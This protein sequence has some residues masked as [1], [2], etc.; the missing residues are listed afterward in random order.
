MYNE[1]LS[2]GATAEPRPLGGSSSL[3]SGLSA[4]EVAVFALL[5]I[6]L[7]AALLFRTARLRARVRRLE[8][9]GAQLSRTVA[10]VQGW[11]QQQLGAVRGEL[12]VF[13]MNDSAAD[14][15]VQAAQ[16]RSPSPALPSEV[17]DDPDA[18]RET[19]AMPAPRGHSGQVLEMVP[20]YSDR[21]DGEEEEVTQSGARSARL[22][23]EPK[24]Y[25]PRPADLSQ[26]Q[27]R[28]AILVPAFRTADQ[29]RLG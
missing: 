24:R 8:R 7:V 12:A 20:S 4:A 9:E 5:V 1:P 10:N 28:A 6:G 29:S 16:K 15:V 11:A 3:S 26:R 18:T 13:C 14:I 17:D 25:D 2:Q 21:A 23:K 27:G 22:L 19:I